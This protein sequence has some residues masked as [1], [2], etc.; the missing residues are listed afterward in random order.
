MDQSIR[1]L[2]AGI[3][4]GNTECFETFYNR[5][6]D[7]VLDQSRR[8]TGRD[9]SFC[10][11]MVQE[12]MVRVIRSIKQMDDEAALIAWLRTVVHSCCYDQLRRERRRCKRENTPGVAGGDHR[13]FADGERLEWLRKQLAA[14]DAG[15]AHLLNLRFRLGWTLQRIGR[16]LGLK[17]GAVDGRISRSIAMLQAKAAENLRDG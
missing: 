16:A 4:S 10:M 1:E 2:T 17:T 13:S 7:Y 3:A 5:W 15:Q 8:A 6:F 14:M 12:T 11:D 9:E